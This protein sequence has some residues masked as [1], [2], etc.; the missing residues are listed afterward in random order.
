MMP[1]S[2]LGKMLNSG[3]IYPPISPYKMLR[4]RINQTFLEIPSRCRRRIH[5]FAKRKSWIV[6]PSATSM[7]LKS[8][9]DSPTTRKKINA[10]SGICRS[11]AVAGLEN[12]WAD[13]AGI[14][15]WRS[16]KRIRETTSWIGR[17]RNIFRMS[18]ASVLIK[19]C[20]I[21]PESN[22]TI[23]NTSAMEIFPV[24]AEDDREKLACRTTGDE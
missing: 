22:T 18:D 10:K 4:I 2:L 21:K 16:R 19:R 12:P 6:S 17:A 8:V 13:A 11:D 5:G 1:T 24:I 20:R 14:S 23:V 3:L 9:L 15:N 7:L